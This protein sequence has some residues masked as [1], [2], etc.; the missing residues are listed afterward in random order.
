MC[1]ARPRLR[2]PQRSQELTLNDR[3]EISGSG[4]YWA[5]GLILQPQKMPLGWVGAT[6]VDSVL[7]IEDFYQVDASATF[8]GSGTYE[9]ESPSSFVEYK[10][11]TPAKASV[12]HEL[13]LWK[14]AVL[15]LDYAANGLRRADFTSERFL[16]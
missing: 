9:A 3:L 11:R 13:D 6:A 14:R 16:L 10:I 1:T 5:F 4:A 2:A 7:S 8:A 12:G 15:S